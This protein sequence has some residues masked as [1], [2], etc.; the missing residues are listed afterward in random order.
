[1]GAHLVKVLNE[2]TADN[3][4]PNEKSV[5]VEQPD[6]PG[7]G[8]TEDP[9]SPAT[10]GVERTPLPSSV[11]L[12]NQVSWD[13]RSPTSGIIRTPLQTPLFDTPPTSPESAVVAREATVQP[14]IQSVECEVHRTWNSESAS[15]LD[16]WDSLYPNPDSRTDRSDCG[17]LEN[18]YLENTTSVTSIDSALCSGSEDLLSSPEFTEDP[19]ISPIGTPL[20]KVTNSVGEELEEKTTLLSSTP[21]KQAAS[22]TDSSTSSD[23]KLAPRGLSARDPNSPTVCKNKPGKGLAVK[24]TNSPLAL[25]RHKQVANANS[26][27]QNMSNDYG[28]QN[29][30]NMLQ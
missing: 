28:T 23:N 12:E 30:E 25:L 2:I 17:S 11:A 6:T 21:L 18:L 27:L 24:S 7:R 14:S 10:T 1:M 15:V 9:R 13:P 16:E 5:V 20:K 8:I 29:K 19:D 26:H 3:N 22:S 4:N